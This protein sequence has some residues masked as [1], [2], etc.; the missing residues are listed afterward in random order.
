MNRSD[1]PRTGLLALVCCGAVALLGWGLPLASYSSPDRRQCSLAEAQAAE[2]VV[3][4]LKSWAAVHEAYVRFGHCDDGSIGQGFSESI[5]I[6]LSVKWDRLGDLRRVAAKDRVF[7]SF[8]VKHIDLT[9]P[10][11][12]LEAIAKNAHQRCG[13]GDSLCG[14]IAKRASER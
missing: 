6:L 2:D 10:V 3:G 5:T 12:R 9:V 4:R 11:E 14:R 7:E 8:V 13:K 1:P